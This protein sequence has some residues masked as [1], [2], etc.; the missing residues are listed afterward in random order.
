[1]DP[2]LEIYKN[3]LNELK[4][5]RAENPEAGS[6]IV[7]RRHNATLDQE[8]Q[9]IETHIARLESGIKAVPKKA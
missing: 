1:M 2:V 6:K 7:D 4:K 9:R 3:F 5:L 8:I